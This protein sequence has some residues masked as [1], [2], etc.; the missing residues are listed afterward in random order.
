[1]LLGALLALWSLGLPDP[2]L[3]RALLALRPEWPVLTTELSITYLQAALE[4]DF[5]GHLLSLAEAV[6]AGVAPGR[7]TMRVNRA[8]A[9]GHSSGLDC[10]LGFLLVAWHA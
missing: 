6:R 3:R 5:S 2:P 4:G 1:M 10:L 8:L 7:L 9:H